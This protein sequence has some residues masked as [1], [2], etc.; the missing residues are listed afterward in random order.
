MTEVGGVMGDR[1]ATW[2]D[3]RLTELTTLPRRARAQS[4]TSPGTRALAGTQTTPAGLATT[5]Q[6]AR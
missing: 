1:K 2:K 6:A 4:C 5:S 3:G